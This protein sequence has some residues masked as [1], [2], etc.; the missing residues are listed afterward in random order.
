MPTK[1]NLPKHAPANAA[2]VTEGTIPALLSDLVRPDSPDAV[3]GEVR[4]ILGLISGSFD[5]APVDHAFELTVNLFRGHFPGYRACNTE[6]HDLRHT[7]DTFLAMARLIHG[8]FIDGETISNRK[9]TV[10]LI[11]ALLHDAG[12]IQ[13]S[14]DTE[15]T[16]AKHTLDHVQRSMEFMENAAEDLGIS[17]SETRDGAAMIFCTEIA[18]D[19]SDFELDDPQVLLAGKILGAADLLAQ[20][21]D[22]TYLE[23]LLFLYREFKE[24]NVGGYESERDLLCRTI[25]FYDAIVMRLNR[26]LGGSDRYMNSHFAARWGIQQNLYQ[27]AIENQKAYLKKILDIP[28]AD[29]RDH[30][31]RYGIV[32][33]VRKRYRAPH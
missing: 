31:K 3:L 16:G 12:Y 4:H 15:G 27:E 18:E 6:Y 17:K 28:D 25:G 29:H 23:K 5:T 32:E 10:G 1:R 20:L 21:A 26:T 8:A 19:L 22:R 30:L 11:S 7:T 13:E 9:I 33:K 24:A 14:H 2:Q